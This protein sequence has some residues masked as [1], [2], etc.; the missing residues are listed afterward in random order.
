MH[1]RL[2]WQVLCLAWR[3]NTDT[4]IEAALY[5]YTKP[6]SSLRLTVTLCRR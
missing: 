6:M 2:E 5:S 4:Y 1:I 3:G